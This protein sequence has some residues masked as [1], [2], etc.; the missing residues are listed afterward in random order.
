[1][2]V[3]NLKN[4]NIHIKILYKKFKWFSKDKFINISTLKNNF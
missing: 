2:N 1:M 4:L 3:K